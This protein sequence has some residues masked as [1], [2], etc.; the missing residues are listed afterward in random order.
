MNAQDFNL[1]TWQVVLLV[2]A[3]VWELVWKG[4]ALWRAAKKDQPVWFVLIM[5]LNTVGILPIIYLLVTNDKK[6]E[7]HGEGSLGI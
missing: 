5:V 3:A 2:I 1:Q 7:E 6:T 4:F